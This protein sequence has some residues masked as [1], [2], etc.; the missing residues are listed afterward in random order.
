MRRIFDTVH[1]LNVEE[2]K[3]VKRSIT[4]G[5]L[6]D[7]VIDLIQKID[8]NDNK[9]QYKFES[10]KVEINTLI[11]EIFKSRFDHEIINQNAD[12][13]ANRLVKKERATQDR[14]SQIMDLQRG[15]LIQSVF[16]KDD[17]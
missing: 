17:K 10:E 16:E 9:R 12:R 1:N 14:Y 2:E 8:E 3:V 4:E 11:Q 13:I 6:N 5:A 15:S 7:Y